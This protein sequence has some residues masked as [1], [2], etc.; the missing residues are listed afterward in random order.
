MMAEGRSMPPYPPDM[1]R[2]EGDDS[3][4]PYQGPPGYEDSD[5]ASGP[6]GSYWPG[7]PYGHYP[8]GP[9][10]YRRKMSGQGPTFPAFL[11]I[12]A[13]ALGLLNGAIIYST[14]A[15][16]ASAYKEM[17][18]ES[19]RAIIELTGMIFIVISMFPLLGGIF[20]LFD[21]T[22]PLV[23][24]FAIIGIFSVGPLLISSVLSLVASIYIFK[25]SSSV[26]SEHPMPGA[27]YSPYPSPYGDPYGNRDPYGPPRYGPYAYGPYGDVQPDYGPPSYG[28]ERQ[29]WGG[30]PPYQDEYPPPPPPVMPP[31]GRMPAQGRRGT[32]G[33]GGTGPSA[34]A[35]ATQKAVKRPRAPAAGRPVEPAGPGTEGRVDEKGSPAPST[36]RPSGDEFLDEKG[37]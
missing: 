15:D 20:Y 23:K 28:T 10:Q 35:R 12:L 24:A 11:L 13:G 26:R 4:P 5:G 21:R 29:G 30:A 2:F 37:H 3:Y 9:Y 19:D 25:Y 36:E 33:H 14:A 8:H 17:G 34:R 1:D 7:P 32:A 31:V 6:Y 27:E 22:S 16:L 18:F